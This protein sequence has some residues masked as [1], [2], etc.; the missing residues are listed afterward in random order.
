MKKE[1]PNKKL[2]ELSDQITDGTHNSPP[3]VEDG[4]PMLD[5]KHVEDGFLIDDSEPEKFIST[6]TDALLAKRCKP[7]TGDILISSRGSIGKIAIVRDGQDFNIMGNMILIRLPASVSRKFAAYYLHSQ[8]IH[9]ES[10]A[11]GV[12]QKGLYLNQI[13]D[14]EIPLPPLPEQKRIVAILDEAFEGIAAATANAEKNLANAREL[15]ESYLN[16]VFTQKGEGW[17]ICPLADCL[18]LITY[19]FTNPMPT[20]DTGPYMVTAKNVVDGRIDYASARHT[21]SDA[22]E[23]LLTDKSR[24]NVGDVLLTKDGTLGRVA[25]VDKPNICINQSVALLRPNDRMERNFM[26]YLL[27]SPDYQ[28]RMVGDA[29]GATI[30][31]IYI[32]RVDKMDVVFPASLPEQQRIVNQIDSFAEETQRLEA[33]RHKKLAGLAELKQSILQKAFAGE[34]PVPPEQILQEAVA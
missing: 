20:T 29:D 2:G 6:I 9:I 11:R 23:K 15:F 19:G 1:W 33:I 24:P 10:I 27:S 16:S 8:I 32:T 3:Y 34:L 30:K 31:H 28:R 18:Q 5:S 25:V 13:R 21:S 12:A 26:R 22:F 4:I 7:R 17:V 14:Y